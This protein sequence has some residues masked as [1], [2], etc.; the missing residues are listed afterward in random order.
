MQKALTSLALTGAR[1]FNYDT[2]SSL[3][4]GSFRMSGDTNASVHCPRKLIDGGTR[5][6]TQSFHADDEILHNMRMCRWANEDINKDADS[7]TY[8]DTGT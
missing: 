8:N 5:A 6:C 4:V 1:A 2:T 3:Y 7:H